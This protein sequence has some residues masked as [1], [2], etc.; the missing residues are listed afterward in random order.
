VDHILGFWLAESDTFRSA[1]WQ[2]NVF[3]RRF[4]HW[5]GWDII[6]RNC[7]VEA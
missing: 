2:G 5:W 7:G 4:D 1:I 6:S 3:H